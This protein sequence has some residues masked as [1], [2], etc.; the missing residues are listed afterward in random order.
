MAAAHGDPTASPVVALP[1]PMS[2]TMASA[3]SSPGG[4]AGRACILPRL[5]PLR[6]RPFAA[7]ALRNHSWSAPG[8]LRGGGSSGL[9]TYI[10]ACTD[11]K[12]IKVQ[13]KWARRLRVDRTPQCTQVTAPRDL[14][15]RR[16]TSSVLLP[17]NILKRLR[18][19]RG[20]TVRAICLVVLAGPSPATPKKGSPCT[21]GRKRRTSL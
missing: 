14:S 4:G 15:A 20:D 11:S 12:Y 18:R 19:R 21:L 10:H 6:P 5:G 13:I 16:G 1:M 7:A 2:F 17:R 8:R 9:H 3:P